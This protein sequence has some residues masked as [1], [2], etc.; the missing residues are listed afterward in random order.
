MW[1]VNKEHIQRVKEELQDRHA[2]ILA[3]YKREVKS[4]EDDLNDIEELERIAY[5]FA[6]KH[7]PELYEPIRV[8]PEPIA[9]L[10]AAS[11]E[12][13]ADITAS[14]AS[15]RDEVVTEADPET[16]LESEDTPEPSVQELLKRPIDADRLSLWRARRSPD[17]GQ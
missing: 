12:G 8:S 11:A 10:E 14:H 16:E 7:I 4:V 17:V 6:A 9:V 5:A 1:N 15:R 2:S 3:R 13:L